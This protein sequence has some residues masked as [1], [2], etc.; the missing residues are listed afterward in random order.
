MLEGEKLEKQILKKARATDPQGF[1]RILKAL[2]GPGSW[3]PK[4]FSR[5]PTLIDVR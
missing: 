2:R 1:L 4:Y 5:V 3:I